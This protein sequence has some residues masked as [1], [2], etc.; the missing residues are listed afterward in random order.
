MKRLSPLLFIALIALLLLPSA[1]LAD[2]DT[3]THTHCICCGDKNIGDHTTHDPNQTW[4]AWSGGDISYDETTKTAYIYLTDD[5]VLTDTLTVNN[6]YTLYLC[7]NGYTLAC[8][9]TSDTLTITVNATLNLTDC[10]NTGKITHETGF[11]GSGVYIQESG[12][13]KA[14][15]F[16][17][18]G[19]W[20]TG[21]TNE[22]YHYADP[23]G[24]VSNNGIFNMYGGEISGNKTAASGGGVY[25]NGTFTVCGSARI[26]G[27]T[28]YTDYNKQETTNNVFLPN[29]NKTITIGTG[30]LTGNASIGVTTSGKPS[31]DSTVQLTS[32]TN[33]DTYYANYFFSDDVAYE[34]AEGTEEIKSYLVLKQRGTT[35]H[36]HC[37]CCGSTSIGNHTTHTANQTWT[38]WSGGDISYKESNTAYIYLTND[39]VLTKSLKVPENYTL[40]LCLNGHSIFGANYEPTV[41]IFGTFNLTDCKSTGNITHK[42]GEAGCGV[43]CGDTNSSVGPFIF[44]MYGGNIAGNDLTN[45][46]DGDGNGGGVR[47]LGNGST[48]LTFNMY[49]GRITGNKAKDFG[50]GVALGQKSTFIMYKGSINS[51]SAGQNAG[52]VMVQS[53]TFNMLDGSISSNS[54]L[55]TVGKEKGNGGGVYVEFNSRA[56]E[57]KASFTMSGGSLNNNTAKRDGGGV[58]NA[59]GALSMTNGSVSYNRAENGGGVYNAGGTLSM[60]D[61]RV[62]YNKAENGGGVYI[63]SGKFSVSGTGIGSNEATTNGGGVYFENGTFTV[64]GSADIAGNTKDKDGNVNNANNVYLPNDRLITIGDGLDTRYRTIGVTT[65]TAPTEGKPVKVAAT[66]D[67]AYANCFFSDAAGYEVAYETGYVVLKVQT[68]PEPDPG[69]TTAP[70]TAP[71]ATPYHGS[72]GNSYSWYTYPTPTPSPVPALP[73]LPKTGDMT[74]WQSILGFLGLA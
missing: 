7:L 45:I 64:S 21:N 60:T 58:Y 51:N 17:M 69:P 67:A 46:P 66:N 42:S 22:G 73:A 10:K 48:G 57:T 31:G 70:T 63:K 1:A 68:Q 62:S 56:G 40:Y 9:K 72:G 55:G 23:G 37:V 28:Y 16:N 35:Q 53:S 74:I 25:N 49:G 50:G 14:G 26:L 2:E 44:N 33:S 47:V 65:E 3:H 34:V 12:S 29:T 36:T 52:G 6:G 71:T 43:Y 13:Y 24:G 30:G 39:V 41:K 27:N 4:T 59:G 5:V 15:T 19:G 38:A 8:K 61:G 18:Y 20:I 11:Y 32:G 54:A